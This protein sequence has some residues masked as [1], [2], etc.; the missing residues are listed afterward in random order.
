MFED[1]KKG[2]EKKLELDAQKKFK[3]AVIRRKYPF[4]FVYGC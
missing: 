4:S 3:V 1:R 2:F